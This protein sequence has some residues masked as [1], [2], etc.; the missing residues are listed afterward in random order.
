MA[1]RGEPNIA[2]PSV[3]LV[4]FGLGSILFL[5]YGVGVYFS[6]AVLEA[7]NQWAGDG[8]FEGVALES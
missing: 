5:H 7:S 6:D 8:G 3:L 1:D 2:F 4:P